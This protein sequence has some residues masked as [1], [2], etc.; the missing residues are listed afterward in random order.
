MMT[1]TMEKKAELEVTE[2]LSVEPVPP[3][4]EL[5]GRVLD[6]LDAPT[7]PLDLDAYSWEEPVPGVRLCTLS[8][9]AA[10]GVRKVLVW[11]K[12][13]ARYPR[14]RHLGD[15]DILV[16]AGRLRDERASYGPGDICRSETG[17]DHSEEVE[18][19]EDCLCF[20]VYR[21]SHEMLDP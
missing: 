17:T 14:H 12:P 5:R 8:E 20:V 13:G 1:K 6:L 15:E 10:R 21:G 7:L 11:A 16:L 2:A 18:G 19:D 4:P 9:D 3:R